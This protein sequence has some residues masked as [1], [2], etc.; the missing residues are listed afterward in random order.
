MTIP[1]AG[2]WRIDAAL[3]PDNRAMVVTDLKLCVEDLPGF[4]TPGRA[5][6]DLPEFS[7]HLV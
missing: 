1:T 5:L 4:L 3:D 2:Q 6:V 7:G